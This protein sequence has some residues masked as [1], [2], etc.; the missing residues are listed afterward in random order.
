MKILSKDGS[1]ES[2]ESVRE[3]IEQGQ[4]QATHLDFST[5]SGSTHG[6][7]VVTFGYGTELLRKLVDGVNK[8]SLR[9]INRP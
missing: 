2:L 3:A 5:E 8:G 6:A 4:A 1:E 7:V 9:E